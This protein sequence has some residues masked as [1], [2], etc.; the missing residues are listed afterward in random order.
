MLPNCRRRRGSKRM[1]R[2]HAL[3]VLAA[4]A[5]PCVLWAQPEAAEINREIGLPFYE[6]QLAGVRL[7]QHAQS[8]TGLWNMRID[9][10][11][12]EELGRN[13]RTYSMP[14]HII[15]RLG[16]KPPLVVGS[17]AFPEGT[18]HFLY[19]PYSPA[20]TPTTSGAPA[21]SGGMGGMG[22][23]MDSGMGGPGSGSMGMGQGLEAAGE[24]MSD[25]DLTARVRGFMAEAMGEEA[26]AQVPMHLAQAQGMM[27]DTMAGMAGMSTLAG[28]GGGSFRPP[29]A[30]AAPATGAA[31]SGGSAAAFGDAAYGG[32]LAAISA[33][34]PVSV[35][36]ALISGG[37]VAEV[38]VETVERFQRE[39]GHLFNAPIPEVALFTRGL[40][41]KHQE[42][43]ERLALAR[44]EGRDRDALIHQQESSWLQAEIQILEWLM[45]NPDYYQIFHVGQPNRDIVF[46]YEP[47]PGVWVSFTINFY[48]W[49]INGITVA[50]NKPWG[51]AESTT[52]GGVRG[53][54]LGDSLEHV[55]N[56]YGWPNGWE[57]Y[58]GRYMLIHYYDDNNIG[59]LLDHPAPKVWRVIRMIIQPRP[60]GVERQMA[61]FRL[62]DNAQTLLID[63]A[64]RGYGPLA[65]GQPYSVERPLHRLT[66]VNPGMDPLPENRPPGILLDRRLG[67]FI[68]SLG[69]GGGMGGMG[70]GSGSMGGPG[71]PGGSGEMGSMGPS[72]PAPAMGQG[73]P[74]AEAQG[75]MGAMPPG[76]MGGPGGMGMGMGM[77]MDTTVQVPVSTMILQVFPMPFYYSYDPFN[78][79]ALCAGADPSGAASATAGV[80]GMGGS[81]M[82]GP[83]MGP[84][85]GPGGSGGSGG[86][87]PG[88]GPG[89]L[90]A[91][92]GMGGMGGAGGGDSAGARM[93]LAQLL[94]WMYIDA[95]G[96]TG[97]SLAFGLRSG[98]G[99]C[100]VDAAIPETQ[101]RWDYRFSPDV[102]AEFGIDADGFTTQI[103]VLGTVWGGA[104]TERGIGLGSNLRD[105]LLRY[106]PP[107]IYNDFTQHVA[108][109]DPAVQFLSYARDDFS[110][111]FGN[112][113]MTMQNHRITAM[114]IL[115]LQPR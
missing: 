4:L 72:G 74:Q 32:G 63:H 97:L 29:S 26:A 9:A 47:S 33:D 5:L 31:Y 17:G 113:N 60:N 54:R 53:V 77:G 38:A 57:S 41:A 94:N 59:F 89:G 101:F 44:A 95:S 6:R 65:Y 28:G 111:P 86:S 73:L 55:I 40:Y 85:M 39:I 98:P 13:R 100:E 42:A 37:A 50:G 14:D 25:A 96:Q 87:G 52:A 66:R 19:G 45:V 22:G 80:G 8:I 67:P 84:T 11:Q 35:A 7:G 88:S 108:E 18:M 93:A 49:Q 114:Q 70:G 64:N 27:G 104:R 71:G 56:R 2:A 1:K 36:S 23:P 3:T 82:S 102:R 69:G 10:M 78:N 12:P 20:A 105:V 83:T 21:S 109:Q 76:M 43:F 106:G 99:N 110:R 58:L 48:T 75:E 34:N 107:L 115:A 30:I 112:L 103:G 81:G 15:M 61:G 68:D 16:T 24:P 62:G 51:G 92:S 79:E 46:T 91:P 90:G